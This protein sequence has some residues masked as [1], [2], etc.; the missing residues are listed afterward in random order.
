MEEKKEPEAKKDAEPK[1]L[2]PKKDPEPKKIRMKKAGGPPLSPELQTRQASYRLSCRLHQGLP[3]AAT[4][5]AVSG[6]PA[7]EDGVVVTNAHVIGMQ[8]SNTS[9]APTRIDVTLYPG[10]PNQA[11]N[12]P[13]H[14]PRCRSD[15]LDLAAIRVTAPNVCSPVLNLEDSAKV[16][17]SQQ[18]QVASYPRATCKSR[19]SASR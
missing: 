4:L 8:N 11:V 10:E 18:V 13:R 1:G 3:T 2:E 5:K 14:A 16:T 7:V 19:A 17:E 9:G 12:S 6:F 15:T